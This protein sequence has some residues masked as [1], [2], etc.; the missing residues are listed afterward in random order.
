[1]R[2]FARYMGL[3]CGIGFVTWLLEGVELR[4]IMKISVWIVSFSG[5]KCLSWFSKC[6]SVFKKKKKKKKN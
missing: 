2:A 5:V 6:L 4:V 1:M 3:T